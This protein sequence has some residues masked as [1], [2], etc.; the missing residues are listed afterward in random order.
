MNNEQIKTETTYSETM[1]GNYKVTTFQ[2]RDGV[3]LFIQ[4]SEGF[5]VYAHRVSGDPLLRAQEVISELQ[6]QPQPEQSVVQIIGYLRS[7]NYGYAV[8]SASYENR[9]YVVE[10]TSDGWK[11]CSCPHWR[12][13]KICKHLREVGQ[14]LDF[15]ADARAVPGPKFIP[16]AK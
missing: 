3:Q 12:F 1:I 11:K 16:A 8:Q 15:A 14:L 2:T 13:K 4:D 6:P 5:Q 9:T 7:G 10:I